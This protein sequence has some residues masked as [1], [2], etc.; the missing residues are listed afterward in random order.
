MIPEVKHTPLPWKVKYYHTYGEEVMIDVSTSGGRIAT[1]TLWAAACGVKDIAGANADLIVRACN[2][3][4][5]L[6]EACQAVLATI[7]ETALDGVVLWIR[8][9]YQAAAVHETATER[10]EAVIAKATD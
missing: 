6:L 7:K 3:H 2:S 10:L 5:E 8:P 9:P 1:V 4:Y